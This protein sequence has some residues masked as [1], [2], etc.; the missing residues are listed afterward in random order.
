MPSFNSTNSLA[1]F[2]SNS[3]MSERFSVPLFSHE[4]KRISI[5]ALMRILKTKS[6]SNEI[7]W[8]I[9]VSVNSAP[10]IPIK[11]ARKKF[12]FPWHTFQWEAAPQ[13]YTTDGIECRCQIKGDRDHEFTESASR[14][15]ICCFWKWVGEPWSSFLHF[16]GSV[17]L[18]NQIKYTLVE[19]FLIS[20][21]ST[22]RS[23]FSGFWSVDI[24]GAIAIDSILK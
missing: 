13:N 2:K 4:N 17:L 12:S 5:I 24:S 11:M 18:M 9:T 10:Y 3:F 22:S 15:K 8:K 19:I 21:F 16:R 14:S 20:L 23:H 6:T 7:G 1:H